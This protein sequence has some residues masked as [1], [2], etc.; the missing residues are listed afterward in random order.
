MSDAKVLELPLSR[1]SRE[2]AH[3]CLAIGLVLILAAA[4][5]LEEA[6][7]LDLRQATRAG[8]ST[9]PPASTGPSSAKPGAERPTS[10]E[11]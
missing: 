4:W 5:Y 11:S 9:S 6:S 10:P 3:L 1:K 7:K 2:R 8:S